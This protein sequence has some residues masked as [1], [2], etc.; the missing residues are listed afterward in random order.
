MNPILRKAG[1]IVFLSGNIGSAMI[2]N[3]DYGIIMKTK[4]SKLAILRFPFRSS[5]E[6]L[7]KKIRK[8][9]KV[10]R[11]EKSAFEI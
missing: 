10:R 7:S 3:S 2:A 11:F 5:W 8:H 6:D 9:I 1:W 4:D